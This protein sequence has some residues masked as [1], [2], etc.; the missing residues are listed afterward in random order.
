MS[1][2]VN[3]TNE[4][5]CLIFFLQFAVISLDHLSVFPYFVAVTFTVE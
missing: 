3:Y 4:N 5:C 2:L 1:P